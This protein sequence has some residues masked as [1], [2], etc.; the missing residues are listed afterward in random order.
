MRSNRLFSIAVLACAAVA[1]AVSG[2]ADRCRIAVSA[3][4]AYVLDGLRLFCEHKLEPQ[5][6]P[7]ARTGLTARERHDLG[8]RPAERYITLPQWRMCPSV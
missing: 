3:A 4:A 6:M 7:H 2:V 5:K 8:H 1:G